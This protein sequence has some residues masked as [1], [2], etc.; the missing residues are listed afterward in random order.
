VDDVI[1]VRKGVCKITL[2]LP[3]LT[4]MTQRKFRKLC[5][6]MLVEPDINRDAIDKLTRYLEIALKDSHAEWHQ[7]SLQWQREWRSILGIQSPSRVRTKADVQADAK[8]R[9]HN[10]ALTAACKQ[11]KAQYERWVKYKTIW[12]DA[13]K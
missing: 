3:Q 8:V 4:N 2:H 7:A 10:K 13:Q 1:T 11:K 9:A 12:E 6:M 5:K